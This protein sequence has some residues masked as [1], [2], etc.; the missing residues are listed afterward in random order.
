MRD[1]LSRIGRERKRQVLAAMDAMAARDELAFLTT[2][3]VSRESGV[4]DGVLFRLFPNRE[5]MLEAWLEAR[6]ARLRHVLRQSAP[7]MGGLRKLVARL[8][9]DAPVMAFLFCQPMDVPW[10]REALLEERER[11]RR[12]MLSQIELDAPAGL[13][14]QALADHLMQAMA[15]AWRPDNP[16]R[17]QE[18]ERLMSRL[19]WEHEQGRDAFPP[20]E[21]IGRLALN[22]SGFVFDP[23]TGRSFTANAVGLFVLRHLQQHGEEGLLDAV[24]G[25]FDVEKADAE[26]DLVEFA[27]WLR[28]TFAS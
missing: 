3:K 18:K 23:E 5:S 25:A 13:P 6:R 10:L 9:N 19:P 24:L 17:E 22:D 28:Q 2:K 26:R 14:A 16:R 15:R 8:L 12:F 7:G 27:A 21:T 20:R 1:E 11:F 4:S